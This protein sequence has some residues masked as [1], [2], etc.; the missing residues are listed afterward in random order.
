MPDFV[1]TAGGPVAVNHDLGRLAFRWG[2]AGRP[3]AVT[4]MDIARCENGVIVELHTFVDGVS[5]V[6]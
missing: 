3:D 2:P 4:G 5:D 1:F 6:S